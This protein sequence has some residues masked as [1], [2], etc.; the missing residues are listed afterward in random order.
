M[1]VTKCWCKLG[2]WWGANVGKARVRESEARVGYTLRYVYSV[3]RC[4]ARD[5]CC[6]GR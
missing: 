3:E 4:R 6:K 1:A 2:A 5:R